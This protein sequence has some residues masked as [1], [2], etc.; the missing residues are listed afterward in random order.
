MY[1]TIRQQIRPNTTVEF[2][3]PENSVNIRQDMKYHLFTTYI[4]TGKQVDVTKTLSEDGLTQTITF[5]WDSVESKT[6]FTNDPVTVLINADSDA[7]R[8]ENGIIL[9]FVSEG[10]I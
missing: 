9:Q 5:L 7:Y 1:Q 2:Y 4:Q 8:I 3:S 6:E 10:E